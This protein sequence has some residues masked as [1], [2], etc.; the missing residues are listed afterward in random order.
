MPGHNGHVSAMTG[1]LLQV[2]SV[3]IVS[4]I[5]LHRE[6]LA[7]LLS[8][9][10]TIDVLGADD[11]QRTQSALRR[12]PTDVALIDAPSPRDSQ[13]AGAL[14]K[15]CAPLRILAIGI[16]ETASDVLACAAAG[17]DGY[18]PMDAALGDMVA[19]IESVMRGELVCSPRVAAS[20]YHSVGSARAVDSP[21]TARE[22]QVAD[23]MNRGL[24]TKEIAWRLGVQSCTAKNHIRNILRKLQVHRRGQAVAK[25][26]SLIGGRFGTSS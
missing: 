22:L 23:L 7:A 11:M 10:P 24:P 13:I 6:G 8:G 12:T 16:R 26:G 2:I 5:R 21:L 9:C 14:R 17:I 1:D 15:I 25:L 3:F 18:V 4:N 19:A 20:L